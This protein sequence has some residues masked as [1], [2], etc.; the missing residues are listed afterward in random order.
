MST[1]ASFSASGMLASCRSRAENSSASRIVERSS[2]REELGQSV[3]THSSQLGLTMQIE[4]LNESSRA[5]KLFIWLHAIKNDLA[6]YHSD[7]TTSKHVEHYSARGQLIIRQNGES[8]LGSTTH[9]SIF[10]HHWR[11][12]KR[13]LD[14]A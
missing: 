13:K 8:L 7:L 6:P 4:L 14:Q 5:V 9:R 2:A 3:Y 12:S 11:P 1:Y 10:Q